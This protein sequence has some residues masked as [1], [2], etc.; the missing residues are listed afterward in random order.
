MSTEEEGKSKGI[1]SG[2]SGDQQS[3]PSAPP[4]YGTFQGLPPSYPQQPS[5]G[6]PQPVPPPGLTGASPYYP[7]GYQGIPGYAVE[8]TPVNEHRH[9]RLPI[10]GCG[11]GWFLFIIG[12]FIAAIPWYVG[13]FI[14]LCVRIDH[15]EKP[16]LIACTIAAV[17]SAV[18]IVI[19]ASSH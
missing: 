10:C 18:A 8:G 9:R 12:F 3:P 15:R 2:G 1:Y 13:A 17:L 5:I 14:L 4:Q 7:H 16:G 6:Y 11:V 19:G